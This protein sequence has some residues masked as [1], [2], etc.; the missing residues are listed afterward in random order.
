MAKAVG[1]DI[2]SRSLKIL[3]LEGS[4]NRLSINFFRNLEI[5]F[6]SDES[7]TPDLL[8][9]AIKSIFHQEHL[10]VDN[11]ILSVPTQDC[12]LREIAVDFK[13]DDHIRQTIKY[14][15]EKYLLSYEI[16]D[17]IVDYR[18][19][20]VGQD[21]TKLFVAS[22]PKK[23]IQQRLDLL[24]LCNIDPIAI[25]LDIMSLVNVANLVPEVTE[26]E[27]VAVVDFGAGSSNIVIIS[28]GKLR[29]VRA[30]RL[31]TSFVDDIEKPNVDKSDS[32]NDSELDLDWDIEQQL[33]V[34]LPMPDGVE[35]DRMVLF[36]KDEEQSASA[37]QKQK[38]KTEFFQ[39]LFKEIRRTMLTLDMEAPLDLVCITGGGSQLEGLMEKVEDAFQVPAI[40]LDF[41][42]TVQINTENLEETIVSAPIALGMA[43][44][45]IDGNCQTMNFRKEE[46]VYT[47]RFEL[48][49][50]PLAILVTFL[51]LFL[52]CLTYFMYNLANNAE[53]NFISV[54][55]QS[56]AVW[57]RNFP[58]EDYTSDPFRRIYDMR[59][60]VRDL[61]ES[62]QESLVPE[63]P[64]GF[65]RW[66]ILFRQF[67]QV[68]RMYNI[69]I[70]KFNL[71]L[72][73]VE[74]EGEVEEDHILDILKLNIKKIDRTIINHADDQ[75]RIQA[76]ANQKPSQEN[77][78]R[79]Y[80]VEITFASNEE[81]D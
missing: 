14:E 54:L 38:K 27:N 34:S 32:A 11:V 5:P 62:G 46:F 30:I 25:D 10:N 1:I 31:G 16:D 43:L 55:E 70:D 4:G 52:S 42:P 57:Q 61:I 68:R 18:K 17:V 33:I 64:D 44:E 56:N 48:V 28:Q 76:Q 73:E 74:W 67:S 63:I 26:K 60:K 77:L 59:V 8:V 47:N 75:I 65:L 49:K 69:T 35:L 36:R 71:G 66:A 80:N 81:D 72:N 20:S 40:Y 41:S 22:V 58:E 12:I 9:E 29:H 50:I 24:K 51:F 23:I 3:E 39:R 15:A 37:A 2:G 45:L 78:K 21:K 13:D 7:K 6:G 79:R 19:I 53:E